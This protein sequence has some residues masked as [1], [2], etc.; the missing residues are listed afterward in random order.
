MLRKVF[1]L[2][3]AILTPLLVGFFASKLSADSAATYNTFVLPPLAPPGYLFGIV[4]SIIYILM[5]I[6]SYLVLE[7]KAAKK[8][9]I[10]AACLYFS[11]LGINFFWTYIFFTL[12]L[13]LFAFFW[14]LLLLSILFLCMQSFKAVSYLGFLL[15]C[16]YFLWCIFAA[17][18]NISLYILNS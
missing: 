4:W 1:Y 15:L 10:K 7:G 16:P 5:G 13:K 2:S 6:A 17:Y 12:D 14:L 18:L 3:M 8:Q 9:K 11:Q